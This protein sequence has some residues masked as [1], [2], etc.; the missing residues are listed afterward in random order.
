[1]SIELIL[2]DLDGV[3]FDSGDLVVAAVYAAVDRLS[4]GGPVSYPHPPEERIVG[5]LGVPDREYA[6]GL[7]LE[8]DEP[9]L[10]EFKRLVAEE[11][12]R[13]AG[14][15]F[16]RLY[17]GIPELLASISRAGLRLALASNCGRPYLVHFLDR[18]DLVGCFELALC[19][20]DLPWGEKHDL[21][22]MVLEHQQTL[23]SEAIYLGDRARDWEAARMAG[24]GFI[25]CLWGYGDPAEF[26]PEVPRCA[27]P[28]EAGEILA[29]VRGASGDSL[30]SP[31][32]PDVGA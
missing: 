29:R 16:G 14:A 23:P 27:T 22:E 12:G 19:N 6:R 10:K 30:S 32:D 8:L 15:G 20:G 21:L 25:A 3:L 11:L 5:L 1:M 2:F 7:G 24:C 17:E 18:F 9:R 31:G 13:Q 4:A 28:A 26:P